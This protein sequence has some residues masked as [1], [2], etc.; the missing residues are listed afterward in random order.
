MRKHFIR[1]LTAVCCLWAVNSYAKINLDTPPEVPPAL[2]SHDLRELTAMRESLMGQFDATRQKI[3]RQAENCRSVEKGSPK[4]SECTAEAQEVKSAVREYRKA[5]EQFKLRL[6]EGAA[7]KKFISG[8]NDKS[9]A[10]LNPHAIAV[11]SHGEFH[12]V[13][14]GGKTLSGQDASG[15][16]DDD[17][18]RLVTGPDG[19]AF[20]TLPDD[21]RLR[22]GPNTE[23]LTKATDTKP[24]Q[25]ER[26]AMELVKGTFR[27]LHESS[28]ELKK[29][30]KETPVQTRHRHE[31]EGK[32][33]MSICVV[34]VRGTEFECLALPDGSGNIKLYSGEVSITSKTGE[35]VTLKP[36]QM[37]SFTKEKVG[38]VMP[39]EEGSR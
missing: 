6:A 2:N 32:I 35:A 24:D 18:A 38:S 15:L 23:F 26:P 17:D 37:I 12:I 30:L 21:T 33:R 7:W 16:N 25:N 3:D 39:I 1:L 20:L 9:S 31:L 4:A 14:A 13:T 34:A 19:W 36:G 28:V 5:L 27:W 11:E 10:K 29:V 22:L 8:M